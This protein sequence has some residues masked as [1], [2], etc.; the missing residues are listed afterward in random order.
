MYLLVS[1]WVL[2]SQISSAYSWPSHE[3][4]QSASSLWGLLSLN[5]VFLRFR[6]VP[7]YICGSQ[8]L[9][10]LIYYLHR[11][12]EWI[13]PQMFS[14]ERTN[15]SVWS[16]SCPLNWPGL[17]LAGALLVCKLSNKYHHGSRHS[18]GCMMSWSCPTLTHTN[19]IWLKSWP[20]PQAG[21]LIPSPSGFAVQECKALV[22]CP[23][24]LFVH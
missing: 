1:L 2:S 8:H 9:W 23:A 5:I 7:T 22:I 16:C 4:D 19:F 12:K 10:L 11:N 15:W 18:P 13:R 21:P 6:H 14:V 3:R 17:L 20:W 24:S